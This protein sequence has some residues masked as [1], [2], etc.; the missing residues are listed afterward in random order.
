[1]IEPALGAPELVLD[2]SFNPTPCVR[3]ERTQ[4]L[5]LTVYHAT[6]LLAFVPWFFS[7]TGVVLAV[8]GIYVFGVLGINIG[9][10]RL[11]THKGFVCPKWLER[12]FAMLGVC[13]LQGG[14]SSW[15]AVHR[16]HHEYAD[17]PP[18]PHSPI[19][20]FLW[21][22][23]GWVCVR[24][25]EMERGGHYQNYAKDILRDPFYAWIE[26]FK[27]WAWLPLATAVMFF[28][29]GMAA[30]LLLGW[31]MA[32]AVQFGLSIMVWGVFVRTVAH[33]HFTWSVNSITHMWGYRNY[34]TPDDSR[35]NA[36]IAVISNGE[37]WHNNHHADPRSARHGHAWWEI[38]VAWFIIRFLEITGLASEVRRPN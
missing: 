21:A 24:N 26:D 9:Y 12:S 6:A 33:L 18:D 30:G 17:H 10:H 36:I 14:P 29:A 37:G 22:H 25:E 4:I 34:E 2:A 1:M 11:L 23:I 35:N 15:V 3:L 19:R 8:L 28:L 31:P 16:R 38:D 20:S 13:C 7:W 27:I 5:G 32:E